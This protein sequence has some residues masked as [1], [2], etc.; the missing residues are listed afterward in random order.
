MLIFSLLLNPLLVITTHILQYLQKP[1]PNNSSKF[2]APPLLHL[3]ECLSI[4]NGYVCIYMWFYIQFYHLIPSLPCSITHH[5]TNRP[6]KSKPFTLG[7]LHLFLLL[8]ICANLH[9]VHAIYS[10]AAPITYLG[11]IPICLTAGFIVRPLLPLSSKTFPTGNVSFLPPHLP[12]DPIK[13]HDKLAYLSAWSSLHDHSK[14]HL[15]NFSPGGKLI[16]IDSGATCCISN[17][18]QD[19]I[20]FSPSKNSVLNGIANGLKKRNSLLENSQ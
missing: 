20:T 19:F 1:S 5:A 15:M 16:C 9:I 14:L 4:F 18:H 6:S 8:Y 11:I 13:H 12:S 7:L 17:N 10:D 3:P 2:I